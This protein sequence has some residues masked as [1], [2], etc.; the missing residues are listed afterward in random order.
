MCN[1]K[2]EGSWD[3]P[4]REMRSTVGDGLGWGAPEAAGL[5]GLAGVTTE[6]LVNLD[7]EF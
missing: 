3:G 7:K 6:G 4:G 1:C 5:P 2:L